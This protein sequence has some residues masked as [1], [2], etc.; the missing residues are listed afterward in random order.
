MRTLYKTLY[1][2]DGTVERIFN[3]PK[4]DYRLLLLDR[5]GKD[6]AALFDD[7]IEDF[8]IELEDVR[9]EIDTLRTALESE[10]DLRM[11]LEK[12]LEENT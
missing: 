2:N 8:E 3:P 10:K 4:D 11:K 9:E 1:L 5:L 6:A 12:E 7:I